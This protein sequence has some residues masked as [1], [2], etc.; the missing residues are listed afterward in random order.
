MSIRIRPRRSLLRRRREE[1]ELVARR[2]DA[3]GVAADHWTLLGVAQGPTAVALDG[4]K[5][6]L[7]TGDPERADLRV[8][9]GRI[10]AI[11]RHE[12]P[13]DA[14]VR[15]EE[16]V[17]DGALLLLGGPTEGVLVEGHDRFRVGSGDF[18]VIDARHKPTPGSVW[19]T[20]FPGR[21]RRRTVV[22][23]SIGENYCWHSSTAGPTTER[24]RHN[25]SIPC[26][27]HAIPFRY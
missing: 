23:R 1:S 4:L 20:P 12:S 25:R 21:V 16:P 7:D 15:P 13:G 24:C 18:E 2:V 10:G 5:R 22:S 26:N 19:I 11:T 14:V 27:Q 17:V 6:G 3:V 9:V 8:V